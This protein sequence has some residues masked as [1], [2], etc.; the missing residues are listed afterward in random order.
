M[1]QQTSGLSCVLGFCGLA[2]AARLHLEADLSEVPHTF[3]L[4]AS[5]GPAR[6]VGDHCPLPLGRDR[7][8]AQ[9]L[10]ATIFGIPSCVQVSNVLHAECGAI[11]VHE[12]PA[13]TICQPLPSGLGDCRVALL[14]R[15]GSTVWPQ[16][17]QSELHISV[18]RKYKVPVVPPS[19]L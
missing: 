18:R 15:T 1:F 17:F 16:M 11:A 8:E 9:L 10:L 12:L 6:L 14:A 13:G 19:S 3:H 5:R 2:L 4:L 7:E